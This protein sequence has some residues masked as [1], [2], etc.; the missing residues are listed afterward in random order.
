MEKGIDL[1]EDEEL[2]AK[3]KPAFRAMEEHVYEAAFDGT[4][5]FNECENGVNDTKRIWWVECEAVIGFVNRGMLEIREGGN[6]SNKYLSAAET[7]WEYIR[8]HIV[9]K[10]EGSEWLSEVN[11]E[12]VP[13]TKKPIVEEWKCPYH[14]G[15][16]CLEVLT[17][18]SFFS[19]ENVF[20]TTR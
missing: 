16:M 14:N 11:T 4:A 3:I 6:D 17:R 5:L 10:R 7:I 1:L 9:D 8:D 2:S 18:L 15:R 13:F 19:E 20:G 12:N